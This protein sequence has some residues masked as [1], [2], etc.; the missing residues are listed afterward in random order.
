MKFGIF[1]HPRRPKVTVEEVKRKL[2]SA[3]LEY[4]RTSPDAGVVVGGDGTF[5][6]YGR[7]LDIPLLFVGVEEPGFLGSRAR[8]AQVKLGE[9][10]DCL[11]LIKAGRYSVVEKGMLHVGFRGRYFDVLTDIFLE[12][13]AF[14]GCMRYTVSV[15][16][17]GA[18]KFKEYAIGNGIVIST[19]FGSTGYYSY[20][21]RLIGRIANNIKGFS[22]G[23]IGVCHIIPMHLVRERNGESRLYKKVKYTIP[24]HST[25]IRINLERDTKTHLFGINTH[26]EGIRLNH[27]DTVTIEG[28]K[29]KA[30]LIEVC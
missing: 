25:H 7:T 26:S 8:L 15:F 13:V 11:R 2:Q 21:D 16:R 5:G 3:D 1:V 27:G 28:S 29:K 12:R 9:L 6:F 22:E 24:F 30:R 14:A 4:S 23:K 19:S 18:L 10:E 17:R 20:P